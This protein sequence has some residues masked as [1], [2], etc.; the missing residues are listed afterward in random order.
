MKQVLRRNTGFTLIELL[1]VIAI[2][3]LL[4]AILFPVFA[5]ARE[6]ARRSSCQSNLKQLALGAMQ[7]VQDNDGRLMPLF[8]DQINGG[9]G[10]SWDQMDAVEPYL[11]SKQIRFCPSSPKYVP[12]VPPTQQSLYADNHYGFPASSSTSLIAL[13]PLVNPSLQN[14]WT[15]TVPLDVIP[16]PSRSCLLMETLETH[17][18]NAALGYGVPQVNV[19]TFY[20]TKLD[21][22]FEGANYAYIDGHVKWIKQSE[23]DRVRVA[24]DSTPGG[25]SDGIGIREGE[26]D[27][28]PIVFSW[29]TTI[30]N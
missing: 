20:N 27:S 9:V 17:A 11:K 24:S 6:N 1:V 28:Y 21:K 7:Y 16:E 8:S 5:K 4:A 13:A 18:G 22:H 25:N 2:I 12:R 10:S 26:A 30:F 15:Y 19:A 29:R 14:K 23:V 3:A